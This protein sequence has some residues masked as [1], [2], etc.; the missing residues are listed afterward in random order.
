VV[1]RL[2]ER[3]HFLRQQ[4]STQTKLVKALADREDY[5][6]KVTWLTSLPGIGILTAME[7]LVE[8]GDISRFDRAEQV[9][10]Y[11]GLTPSEYSTVS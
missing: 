5:Q 10:A 11:V 9:A 1:E 8:L 4:I 7:L 2:L 6:D 3:Y